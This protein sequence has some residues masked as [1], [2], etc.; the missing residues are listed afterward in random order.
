S[1]PPRKGVGAGFLPTTTEQTLSPSK[2]PRK[3]VGAGFLP[4]TTEQ[5]LSLSKPA[6]TGVG[7]NLRYYPFPIINY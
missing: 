7:D 3:G 2:P 1:K 5:T 6:R 4:T